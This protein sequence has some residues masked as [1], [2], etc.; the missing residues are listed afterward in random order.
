MCLN[1]DN[2]RPQGFGGFGGANMG[3]RPDMLS[4]QEVSKLLD[5]LENRAADIELTRGDK[6]SSSIEISLTINSKPYTV[7]VSRDGGFSAVR[8]DGD[9]EMRLYHDSQVWGSPLTFSYDNAQQGSI[10]ISRD[11]AATNRAQSIGR[12]WFSSA[13]TDDLDI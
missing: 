4:S 5:A 13:L 1:Y 7:T 9:V 8:D 12:N 6:R 11:Q 3:G 10:A 2:R